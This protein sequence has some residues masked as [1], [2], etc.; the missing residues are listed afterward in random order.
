[1]N[2]SEIINEI[3][4]QINEVIANQA[5]NNDEIVE[6][7]ALLEELEAKNPQFEQQLAGLQQLKVNAQSLIDSASER[8]INLN[9]NVTSGGNTAY[10]GSTVV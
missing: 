1:M 6:T 8:D 10:S 2:Y 4:E 9:I 7:M 5:A 3:Q